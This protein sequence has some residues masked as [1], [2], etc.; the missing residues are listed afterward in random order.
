VTALLL[1]RRAAGHGWHDIVLSPARM[2]LMVRQAA[3]GAVG[4]A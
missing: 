1:Y 2:R 3:R 4:R